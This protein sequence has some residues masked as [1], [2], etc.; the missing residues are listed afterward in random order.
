MPYL[1]LSHRMSTSGRTIRGLAGFL[2]LAACSG[3][4][5]DLAADSSSASVGG[6]GGADGGSSSL[7]GFSS[8]GGAPPVIEPDGPPKLTVVNGIVDRD[9]LALCFLE[10]PANASDAA[11]P[12]PE[13]DLDYAHAAS[14]SLPGAP[15]PEGTDIEILV[16]TGDLGAAGASDCRAIADDPF[17]F[18]GLEVLSLGI[19]PAA[20]FTQPRSTLLAVTGCFGGETHDGDDLEDI[21]GPS[22]MPDSPTP[23]VVFAPLSRIGSGAGVGLQVVNATG[24]IDTIAIYFRS[25]IDGTLEQSVAQEV[26]PG[27]AAPFPPN[28]AL[29]ASELGGPSSATLRAIID[30]LPADESIVSLGDAMN[31]GGISAGDFVNGGNVVLIAVGPSPGAPTN[32]WWNPFAV[33]A[34]VADP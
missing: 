15:I 8:S 9:S 19:A 5:T 12:W 7:G 4:H 17:G 11:E 2:L 25:A 24:A 1:D 23:G 6:A 18:A 10:S 27:A 28:T 26:V 22:Y 21:C 16:L 30:L 31:A 13:A 20:T 14:V 34:V 32:S 29:S 33:V 3:S